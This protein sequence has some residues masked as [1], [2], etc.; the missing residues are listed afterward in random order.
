M[1]TVMHTSLHTD[2]VGN[3][4]AWYDI[5]WLQ[6]STS[7]AKT[8]IHGTILLFEPKKTVKHVQEF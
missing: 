4:T 7:L 8:F 2:L 3:L 6:S 5:L 1:E